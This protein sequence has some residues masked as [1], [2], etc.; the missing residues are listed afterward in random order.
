MDGPRE[1]DD[2]LPHSADERF[3]EAA[4]E[5]ARQAELSGEV[6]IGAIVVSEGV[7]V[8]SGRN[9]PVSSN[10]P[11]AHAEILALRA[12]ALALGDYRLEGATLYATIEPCAM[13]AGA[14]VNARIRR[15]V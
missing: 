12:A 5:L 6:P 3:M 7:I 13:C 1:K 15:L 14:I 9:S 2:E 4:L 10:D 8:G 11:T